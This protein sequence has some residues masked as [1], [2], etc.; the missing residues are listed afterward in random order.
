MDVFL[1]TE[2]LILRRFTPADVDLLVD[3]DGDPEVMR[4]LTGGVPTPREKI[5]NEFLPMIFDLYER[6][7]GLGYWAAIEKASGSFVGW[8]HL[9]PPRGGGRDEAELGYRLR[10]SAWGNGYA[11][12]GSVAL[13]RTAFEELGVRRI[14][15]FTMAVNA[16]S[17]RV[18]E[19]AGL[20]HVRTFHECWPDPIPGTEHGEVEYELRKE[21][22]GRAP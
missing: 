13:I 16:A 17:R 1:E 14:V 12:E 3:L 19:K 10:K 11:T 9:R 8:F 2:R 7:P 21:D 5:E 6:F 4:Y 18:M 22:W 20:T 15:A